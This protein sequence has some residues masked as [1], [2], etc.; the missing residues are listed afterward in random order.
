[1]VTSCRKIER[2]AVGVRERQPKIGNGRRPSHH[3]SCCGRTSGVD[4]QSQ[5]AR[6]WQVGDCE[7]RRQLR[8]VLRQATLARLA[9]PKTVFHNVEGL[10][11]RR[12]DAG[13]SLLDPRQVPGAAV[14]SQ[15]AAFASARSHRPVERSADAFFALVDAL[16]AWVG[17][18]TLGVMPLLCRKQF[19]LRR[20]RL[21]PRWE[22]VVS[23]LPLPARVLVLGKARLHRRCSY[24]EAP[25]FI[26]SVRP[27][28]AHLSTVPA[29]N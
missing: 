13:L 15:R 3:F 12:P 9:M 28:R 17:E 1:M 27:R 25:R 11:G 29:S 21:H 6:Q 22:L 26:V 16:V 10:L 5:L 14:R 19:A 7:Q 8:R 23:R 24:A 4:V 2:L 20:H 18:D